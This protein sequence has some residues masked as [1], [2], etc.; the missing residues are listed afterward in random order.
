VHSG[1]VFVQLLSVGALSNAYVLRTGGGAR[2][3]AAHDRAGTRDQPHRQPEVP[4]QRLASTVCVPY[5]RGVVSFLL[6]GWLVGCG[7]RCRLLE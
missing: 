3:E 1:S 7:K 6:S 5:V 2:S 4:G